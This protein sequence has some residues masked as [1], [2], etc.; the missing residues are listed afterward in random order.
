MVQPTGQPPPPKTTVSIGLLASLSGGWVVPEI[1]SAAQV[2]VDTI[3]NDTTLLPHIHLQLVV[4][5]AACDK[6]KGMQA[7]LQLFQEGV[8]VLVGPGCSSVCEQAGVLSKLQRM[9][10]I[11]RKL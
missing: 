3:N 5:D 9:P 2:A 1:T 11:S 6:E 4:R 10:Q 7:A 8:Q